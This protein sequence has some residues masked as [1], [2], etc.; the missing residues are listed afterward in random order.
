VTLWFH[1]AIRQLTNRL[2]DEAAQLREVRNDAQA[3]AERTQLSERV[4]QVWRSRKGSEPL[5]TVSLVDDQRQATEV[6]STGSIAVM[7][8][9][10]PPAKPAERSSR[11]SQ[12]LALTQILAAYDVLEGRTYEEQ[13]RLIE[14]IFAVFVSPDQ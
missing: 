14:A 13:Q 6:R 8:S 3:D 2:K 11:E 7:N 12:I 4:E 9:V 10:A 1:G 5:P